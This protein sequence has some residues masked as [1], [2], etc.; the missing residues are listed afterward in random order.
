[1]NTIA[2]NPIAIPFIN[3]ECKTK[4]IDRVREIIIKSG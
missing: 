1:M 4:V 3:Y 2:A